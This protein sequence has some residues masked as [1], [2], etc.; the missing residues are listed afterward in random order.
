MDPY[1]VSGHAV[2]SEG[3]QELL[4]WCL[5]G[6][7]AGQPYELGS[8]LLDS[9]MLIRLADANLLSNGAG[10]QHGDT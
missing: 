3:R 4:C 9:V 8:W 1:Q 10:T 5:M 2:S 7:G 6:W